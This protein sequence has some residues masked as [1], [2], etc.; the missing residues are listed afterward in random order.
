[1]VF[2]SLT[3][4]F[5]FLSDSTLLRST[6]A[7]ETQNIGTDLVKTGSFAR[8]LKQTIYVPLFQKAWPIWAG[9]LAYAVANIMMTA[10]ARGLGVFPQIA[11]WGASIYNG[12]LLTKP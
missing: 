11:M 7:L 1:M 6:T 3:I 5:L 9:A 2:G 12:D 4:A 8:T 10:Y